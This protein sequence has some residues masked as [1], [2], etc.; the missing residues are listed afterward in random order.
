MVSRHWQD[1]RVKTVNQHGISLC[2]DM[3]VC[4]EYLLPLLGSIPATMTVVTQDFWR[5]HDVVGG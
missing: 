5:R 2:D 1:N 3:I 4:R